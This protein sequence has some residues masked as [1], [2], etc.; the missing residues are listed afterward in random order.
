M[1]WSPARSLMLAVALRFSCALTS[2]SSKSPLRM[3]R[4][5]PSTSRCTS[6]SGIVTAGPSWGVKVSWPSASIVTAPLRSPW[7][8]VCT[9]SAGASG[10]S[11]SS[12]TQAS[13]ALSH[14][15]PRRQRKVRGDASRCVFM[16]GSTGARRKAQRPDQGTLGV[17]STSDDVT[18]R[19]GFR[20]RLRRP[21]RWRAERS[22]RP[23][24]LRSPQGNHPAA[25]VKFHRVGAARGRQRPG[26]HH[27][28][29]GDPQQG[30]CP[31]RG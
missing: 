18:R 23:R 16:R 24:G 3:T 2:S 9:M 22:T 6:A 28:Q 30:C 7:S 20:R 4:L 31:L 29:H 27:F 14:R 12:A 19:L 8:I 5:F 21:L 1:W 17:V 26:C 25:S 15:R 11:A 10:V 13:I